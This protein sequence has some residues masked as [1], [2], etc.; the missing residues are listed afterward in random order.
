MWRDSIRG[1]VRPMKSA[2]ETRCLVSGL[3]FYEQSLEL[4]WFA[5]ITR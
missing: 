3:A 4:A 1:S 5:T 2:H